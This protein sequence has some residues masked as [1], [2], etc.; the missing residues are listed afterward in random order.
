MTKREEL[1]KRLEAVERRRFFLAMKDGWDSKD[2]DLDSELV[3][4]ERALEQALA[5]I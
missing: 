4:E 3:A 2:Y 1:K 5:A